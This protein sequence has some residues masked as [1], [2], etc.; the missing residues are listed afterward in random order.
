MN[1]D[2]S[3]GGPGYNGHQR[4]KKSPV[5]TAGRGRPRIKIKEETFPNEAHDALFAGIGI[6]IQC[7]CVPSTYW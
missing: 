6:R 2:V 5:R 7:E 3:G 1:S 4:V